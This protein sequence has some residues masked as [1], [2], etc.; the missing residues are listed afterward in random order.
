MLTACVPSV[1][2]EDVAAI[3]RAATL[4]VEVRTS[5][6]QVERLELARPTAGDTAARGAGAAA[7]ATLDAALQSDGTAI[8][9]LPLAIPIGALIGAAGAPTDADWARTRAEAAAVNR[10][11]LDL[12]AAASSV[13]PAEAL[14][15]A[16]AREIRRSSPGPS[17]CVQSRA[18]GT[19]CPDAEQG[20]RIRVRLAQKVA[21]L[22][23]G[24]KPSS[25]MTIAPP[26]DVEAYLLRQVTE[27][28]APGRAPVC[29]V[30][31]H[32]V[33]IRS[34]PGYV[35]VDRAQAAQAVRNMIDAAARSLAQR[36][37]GARPPPGVRP[38]AAPLPTSAPL[39][40]VADGRAPRAAC[41]PW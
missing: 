22:G 17:A 38:G 34:T 2:P 39:G 31:D 6:L 19:R 26:V 24:Y 25:L 16:L 40:M 21:F 11:M 7:G 20:V 14:E 41:P 9:L 33:S 30:E 27:I 23:R 13:E 3:S 4:T 29:F 37:F 35:A 32:T 8:L 28:A 10:R 18:A 36:L 15:R 12:A 1:P 5:A